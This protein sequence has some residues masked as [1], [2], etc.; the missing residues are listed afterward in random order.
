MAT[1]ARLAHLP[2]L[3]GLRGLAVVAVLLFHGGWAGAAG[4]FLGVDVFF[5]LSGFL[6]TSLLLSEQ[7]STGTIALRRFWS[8]RARRLVPALLVVVAA[9]AA[10]APLFDPSA[11][12]GL[13]GDALAA[14]AHV[15]NWRFVA[16]G[17]DYFVRTS[18]PSPLNHLWSVAIEEQFYVVW[19]L[20]VLVLARRRRAARWVGLVAAGGAAASATAMVLLHGAGADVSRLYYGTDTRA[21]TVLIG[22]AAAA[23]LAPRGRG[24]SSPTAAR[25]PRAVRLL[26]G[27][28]AISAGVNL[29]AGVAL[30]EGGEAWLYDGGLPL[31]SMAAAILIVHVVLIPD[32]LVAKVLGLGPL[33]GLGRLSYGLY[34]WHWPLFLLLT[35]ARTGLSGGALLA[36]RLA[37]TLALAFASYRLLESPMRARHLRRAAWSRRAAPVAVVATVAVVLAGTVAVPSRGAPLDDEVAGGTGSLAA[38][39][40]P[41]DAP[42]PLRSVTLPPRT[43]APGDPLR[44]LVLGDSV[45]LTL[46]QGLAGRAQK[47]GMATSSAALL[48]CGVA[49]GGPLR[50]GGREQREPA[51]CPTWPAHWSKALDAQ[52]PDVVVVVVGRWEVVDRFWEGRWAHLGEADYDR[53][54]EAE[55]DEAVGL[56]AARGARVA[57]ATAPY[58]SRGERPDGGRWPEDDPRRVDRLNELVRSVAG[59]HPGTV[60]TIDLGGKTAKDGGY[61]RSLDGVQLR[62]DGVHLTPTGVRWLAPWLLPQIEALGPEVVG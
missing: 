30:V 35:A 46:A 1:H 40:G 16:E 20:V 29:L 19:P 4:G 27:A 14:L 43:R 53:Y 28:A 8:R 25:W 5:V 56:A 61:T 59:R 33:G 22:A 21:H 52:D 47:A 6:I 9:V 34:L 55:L 12:V 48:G 62:Y 58:Y 18:A 13:R 60:N 38:A 10:A 31:F 26:L 49:R 50:H 24:A 44:V 39:P 23:L 37:A 41:L 15:A 11:M 32:G 17:A 42:P 51:S 2:A 3:D 54:I 45:A 36:V 57:L 7:R